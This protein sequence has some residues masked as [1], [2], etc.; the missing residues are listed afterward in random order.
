MHATR[1]WLKDRASTA[2]EW[3]F[4]Q[5]TLLVFLP[6]RRKGKLR[7]DVYAVESIDTVRGASGELAYFSTRFLNPVAEFRLRV[8]VPEHTT[9]RCSFV[10]TQPGVRRVNRVKE[11]SMEPCCEL[12]SIRILLARVENACCALH[13]KTRYW[14]RQLRE[15]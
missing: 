4:V 13:L 14:R 6:Q 10:S 12:L 7:V 11:I 15:D 8:Q 9:I 1:R 5:L 3:G 2:R